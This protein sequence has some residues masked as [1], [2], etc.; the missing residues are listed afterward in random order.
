MGTGGSQEFYFRSDKNSYQQGEKVTLIGKSIRE[1]GSFQ[2]GFVHISQNGD[3]INSKPIVYDDENELLKTQFWASQSGQLDYE[4]ELV[5]AG[6]TT[7]VSEGSIQV[8]ESQVELN[9][10]Y[11][12]REPLMRLSAL[13]HGS[14]QT[15]DDRHKILDQIEPQSK[16]EIH[17]AKIIL[18]DNIWLILFILGILTAEW[19]LRRRLGLM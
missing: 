7:K 4:V 12:K 14:F 2:D 9:R 18:H 3:R 1:Q 6:E 19:V 13:A 15:W 5:H 10:V 16:T 8:Q 11:L 17:Y